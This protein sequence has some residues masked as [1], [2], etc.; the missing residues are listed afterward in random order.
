MQPEVKK[1][2]FDILEAAKSIEQYTSG[3][4]YSDY[5]TDGMAQ[6]AVERKFEIIGEALS[7]IGRF[8]CSVL[9]NISEYE[10]IISFRNVISHGYDSIDVEIVWDAIQNH[11]PVLKHE[12]EQLLGSQPE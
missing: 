8:D 5:I 3:L 2:L 9:D 7:R 1:C 12:I 10:R 11:L 6:A 4:T